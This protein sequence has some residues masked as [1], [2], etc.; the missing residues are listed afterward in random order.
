MDVTLG[1]LLVMSD[2]RKVDVVSRLVVD[3]ET[4]EL[5]DSN[6]TRRSHFIVVR[7]RTAFSRPLLLAFGGAGG[8]LRSG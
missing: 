3:P 2:C 6:R 1:K 8:R 5:R 7:R 4:E